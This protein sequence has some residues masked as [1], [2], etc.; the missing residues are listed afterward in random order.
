[1]SSLTWANDLKNSRLAPASN[2]V[3]NTKV[4]GAASALNFR[5]LNIFNTWFLY[6]NQTWI[7]KAPSFDGPFFEFF[8]QHPTWVLRYWELFY[9]NSLNYWSDFLQYLASFYNITNLE[10]YGPKFQIIGTFRETEKPFS[11]HLDPFS[12]YF[13][14]ADFSSYFYN[15]VFD[16]Y[17][18][19]K[20]DPN[21]L[22]KSYGS[23]IFEDCFS[24]MAV[25]S[26]DEISDSNESASDSELFRVKLKHYLLDKKV[27]LLDPGMKRYPILRRNPDT[28][29]SFRSKFFHHLL[30]FLRNY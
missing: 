23:Y 24:D 16:L 29:T 12:E 28:D 18:I 26:N 7:V 25:T 20:C 10:N 2:S 19:L 21:L 11:L 1:M 4:Y 22:Q 8:I 27:E 13:L 30:T 3:S 5:G 14:L 6:I 15:T 17:Y 9:I